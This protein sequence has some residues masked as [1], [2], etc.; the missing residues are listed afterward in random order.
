MKALQNIIDLMQLEKDND[1]V[2]IGAT[3][4]VLG[5]GRVFG[6]LTLAQSLMAMSLTC[7]D[8]HLHSLH[9]YFMRPGDTQ[10]STYYQVENLRD[11]AGFSTR[12]VLACQHDRPIFTMQG[13]FQKLETGVEHQD[14][15]PNVPRP[16]QLVSLEVIKRTML[17]RM[18]EQVALRWQKEQPFDI[19][20]VEHFKEE[21]AYHQA[22]RHIWFKANGQI[23]NHQALHQALL[24]Y[25]SDFYLLLTALLPHGL[26]ALNPDLRVA[27]LDHAMWF[28]RE[29]N[30]NDWVLYCMDS[31]NAAGARGFSRGQFYNI[32]GHLIASTAQEGLIRHL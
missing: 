25:V 10:T 15:M 29:V 30:M 2:F 22:K 4:D 16:E 20:P 32:E 5:T 18:P 7:P 8:R 24:L 12:S 19:R 31:P 1:S 9:A 3:Q 6:G 14:F 11:G 27:S 21:I 28:H 17:D 13:S 23:P 26:N